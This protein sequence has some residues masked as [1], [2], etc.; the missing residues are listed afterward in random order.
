[1]LPAAH[2]AADIDVKRADVP[3]VP[4]L[5]ACGV[6]F[7]ANPLVGTVGE[8]QELRVLAGKMRH[9]VLTVEPVV[10]HDDRRRQIEHVKLPK[11]IGERDL[12]RDVPGLLAESDGL[13]IFH[14]VQHEKLDRI[15]PVPILV[16]SLT[17]FNLILRIRRESRG[18]QRQ[19][20]TRRQDS[21]STALKIRLHS[22]FISTNRGEQLAVNILSDG[23]VR[24][25]ADSLLAMIPCA[26]TCHRQSR[27]STERSNST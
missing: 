8:H 16:E 3:E 21:L 26:A 17:R 5:F 12:V 15:K 11:R 2:D 1:M 25:V 6:D 13:T 10:G 23:G 9:V 24:T 18:V 19:I 14:R 4:E 22:R 7:R 20:Q 27:P